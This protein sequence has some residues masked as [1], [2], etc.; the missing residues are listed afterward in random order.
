MQ[1]P[2]GKPKNNTNIRATDC[3]VAPAR[4]EREDNTLN[5]PMHRAITVIDSRGQHLLQLQPRRIAGH[6]GT[7]LAG[8]ERSW[9]DM[10][11]RQL[12]W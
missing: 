5:L 12:A 8:D 1:M 6:S 10:S 3:L 4:F 11:N 9:G 7:V 2:T